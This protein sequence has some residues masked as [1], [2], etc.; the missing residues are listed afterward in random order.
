MNIRHLVIFIASLLV[1]TI[2]SLLLAQVFGQSEDF[3]AELLSL[4][5]FGA[6]I[7]CGLAVAWLAEE[8]AGQD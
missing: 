6:T 4:Y 8:F 2:S 3:I 5:G 1:L 7:G